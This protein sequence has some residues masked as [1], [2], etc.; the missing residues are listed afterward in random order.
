MGWGVVRDT[1]GM[2]LFRIVVLGL[3][4]SGLYFAGEF[5]ELAASS[6]KSVSVT[7]KEELID[8]VDFLKPIIFIINII[9]AWWIISALRATAD[10]LRNMN[11]LSKLRRHLRLRCLFMTSFVIMAVL[12]IVSAAQHF[13]VVL[14]PDLVW[15]FEAVGH[16]TY[17]LVLFG[18]AVLWRP[19]RD[20]QNYVMQMELP[21]AGDGDSDLELSCVV[22]SADDMDFDGNYKINDAITS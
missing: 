18:V 15:I 14:S 3:L 12:L 20:A 2:A 8:L 21:A 10:Y 19:N 22:P 4:Y 11:Q 16:G 7:E 6:I 1:L 9:F 17:L 5:F 13:T